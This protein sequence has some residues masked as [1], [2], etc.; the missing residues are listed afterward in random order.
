MTTKE[1]QQRTVSDMKEWQ[2]LEKS[3]IAIT[4]KVMEMTENP[5]IHLIMEIIQ[6]DST[7]HYVVQQWIA[8]SLESKTV[9]LNPDE[10]ERLWD[11]IEQHIELER[12]S[13]AAAEQ[14]LA[15]MKGKS[16]VVQEYLINYLAQ[17]ERKHN[18]LLDSLEKIKKKMY[19]YG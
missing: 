8:D 10:L 7:M 18:N 16:M 3:T 2:K 13:V 12:K 5:I 17:D 9:S 4:G 6:R 19:P 1:L 11:T 15:A 14:T